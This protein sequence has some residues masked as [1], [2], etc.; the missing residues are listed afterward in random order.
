MQLTMAHDGQSF[1]RRV[2]I[3][4]VGTKFTVDQE[5]SLALFALNQAPTSSCWILV[6][7]GS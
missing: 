4:K 2:S 1:V 5:L 3:V 6:S 7:V